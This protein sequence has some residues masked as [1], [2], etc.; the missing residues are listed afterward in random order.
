MDSPCNQ[1]QFAP[2]PM[3]LGLLVHEIGFNMF[4]SNKKSEDYLPHRAK[5]KIKIFQQ[6]LVRLTRDSQRWK[7]NNFY[8]LMDWSRSPERDAFSFLKPFELWQS[9]NYLLI[10]ESICE[11]CKLFS[12]PQSLN[13]IF[14][15]LGLSKIRLV[16]LV[17]ATCD[18]DW[19]YESYGSKYWFRGFSLFSK[20]TVLA[21]KKHF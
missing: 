14:W 2:T 15:W 10:Y 17:R 19:E 20:Q 12:A 18:L 13:L 3:S 9:D 1:L 8:F 5:L 6:P 21:F 16:F 11:C 4:L 7:A